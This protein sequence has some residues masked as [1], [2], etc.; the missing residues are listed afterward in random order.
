MEDEFRPF[1]PLGKPTRS[2]KD[3]SFDD[4]VRQN[5]VAFKR[6]QDCL[7]LVGLSSSCSGIQNVATGW[8]RDGVWHWSTGLPNLVHV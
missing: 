1:S 7:L 2:G 5:F 6:P 8:D 3:R 4:L